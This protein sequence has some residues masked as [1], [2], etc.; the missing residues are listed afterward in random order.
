MRGEN[1]N[2][3][4]VVDADVCLYEKCR[5]KDDFEPETRWRVEM[6]WFQLAMDMSI[7]FQLH[8]Q[9]SLRV[10][11]RQ[12]MGPTSKRGHLDGANDESFSPCDNS[13]FHS[14]RRMASA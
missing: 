5:T 13:F 1:N 4:R 9:L 10:I 6:R 11:L 12:A 8:S 3:K 14:K 7:I 2:A